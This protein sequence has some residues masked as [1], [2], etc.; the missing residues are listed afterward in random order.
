MI[1]NIKMIKPL[2]NPTFITHSDGQIDTGLAMRPET[3]ESTPAPSSVP[4]LGGALISKPEAVKT[5]SNTQCDQVS[6]RL[7]PS[8]NVAST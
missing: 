4:R 6:T 2:S 3:Q 7:S 5:P 1:A 8:V